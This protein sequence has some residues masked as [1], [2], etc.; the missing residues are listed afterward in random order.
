MK[1]RQENQPIENISFSKVEFCI[2]SLKVLACG[3]AAGTISRT[4]VAPLERIKT[5]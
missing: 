4:L 5:L 3:A 1:P 2:R